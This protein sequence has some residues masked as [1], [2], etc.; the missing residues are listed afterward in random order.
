MPL[1]LRRRKGSP[2]WHLRGTVLGQPCEESTKT[3]D[4]K[5]AE[6]IRI[7]R[8][9]ELE[10]RAVFGAEATVTFLEA[11][12][13]YLEAGGEGRFLGS[14]DQDAGRWTGLIG[15]FLDTPVRSI[16]QAALDEAARKLYPK[17]KPAT[18]VRQLYTP[19]A[20]VLHHA[21]AK[22]KISWQRVLRPKV[23]KPQT[24]SATPEQMGGLLPHC[25]LKLRRLMIFL[26]YTGRR[27]GEC[28]GLEW[29]KVDL[30]AGTAT[31]HTT[32][33]GDAFTIHLPPVVVAMLANVAEEE[34]VGRVF[35][36]EHRWSVYGPL[37]R[38]CKAAGVPYLTPHQL[39]RHTFATWLRRHV[40]LDIKGVM[41]AGGWKDVKSVIR[42]MHV[43]PAETAAAANAL[44]DVTGQSGQNPGAEKPPKRKGKAA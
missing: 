37:R 12:V 8:E 6:S 21:S 28:I 15:H 18:L 23:P 35:G 44:P 38:A 33:N 26:A 16:D 31:L 32:K 2:F 5:L 10:R 30:K 29:T 7:R 22:W 40:G 43:T 39:G 4:R 3:A 9:A 24:K 17:G 41:D 36:Y 34:R 1:R 11:A 42:Y 13:S 19:M 14:W 25:D 27:I 20:A